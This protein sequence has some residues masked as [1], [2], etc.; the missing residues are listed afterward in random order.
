MRILAIVTAVTC[1]VGADATAQDGGTRLLQNPTMSATQIAFEYAND[2]WVVDRSGG[3]ARRLTSTPV[4]EADVELSPD[5]RWIAFTGAYD[6]NLDVYVMPV[7]GGQPRRLTWHPGDDQVRGWTPDGRRVVFLSGRTNAPL[8][9]RFWTVGLDADF[10][11]VMP[12]PRAYQGSF[13]PDGR[14]FA[15]RMA[16]PTDEEWR[17][18]RG[19]QNRPIW[20]LDLDDYDLEEVRPWDDS[21]DQQPVW[22]GETVYFLSDRDWTMNVWSYDT[23]TRELRQVTEFTDFDVKSLGTD[24]KTLVIE[25]AGWI[26]TVDPETGGRQRLEITVRG[27]FPWMQPRWADVSDSVTNAQLSA[28]GSEVLFE[29]RGDIL[30]IPTDGSA[31]RN[32]TA[33]SGMAERSPAASPDGRWVSWFSDAS[34]E[35]R[36]VIAPLHGQGERREIE[37]PDPKFYYTPAWSPDSRKVAFVGNDLRLWC[38]DIETET[39][40]YVDTEAWLD[41]STTPTLSP[42][43]SPDSRWIAYAK[44]LDNLLHAIFVYS[45][46]TGEIRQVTDG[47]ADALAPAWD[48][49]GKYLSFLAGTDVDFNVGSRDLANRDP[50]VLRAVYL[51]LLQRG[52]PSPFLPGARDGN[53]N[54]STAPGTLTVDAGWAASDGSS[55]GLQV[56]IDFSGLDRRIVALPV[57]ERTYSRLAAGPEGTVFYLETPPGAGAPS[58]RNNDGEDAA[59]SVL[60]RYDLRTR[61]D[62]ELATGV[63]TFTLSADRSRVLYRTGN[64]WIVVSTER[65]AGS[66]NTTA[67]D[68]SDL[69]V[70]IDPRA[71]FRQMFNE[72]WRFQRDYLYAD[73]MH[74]VD[75]VATKARYAPLLE[76]VRHRDDLSYLLDWMGSEV[77]IGHSWVRGGD[78]PS[79]SSLGIGLLGADLEI[80]DGRYRIA[81]VYEGAP[82]T[83][84]RMSPLTQPGADVNEGEYLLAVNGV[85]LRAPSNPYRLFLGTAGNETV[86]R[87]GPNPDGAGSRSVTVVPLRSER[88][89]RREQWTEDNRR[90]VDE[91]S[92]G[93]L[94]YVWVPNNADPGY[95]DFN[96]YYFAQQDREGAVIDER[97]NTGGESGA[98]MIDVLMREP[99]GY[100]NNPIADRRLFT[101]PE[102][103]IWGPKVMIINEHAMSGGDELAY[104]FRYYGIGP[105]VGTRTWG[106]VVAYGNA[107]TLLDGGRMLA[108]RRAFLD[109]DGHWAV[110]NEGVAPDIEVE[111]TPKDVIAGRD[112]QLERAVQEALR[113]LE[114]QRFERK[115]EPP[116]PVRGRR[117]GGGQ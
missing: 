16:R 99:H 22:V 65:A 61:Q 47:L 10:P 54:A 59:P 70:P 106:G 97:F 31:W 73:N 60:H 57:P 50:A 88:G 1:L 89:L 15:Y 62:V 37:M 69:R 101:K 82:W 55:R 107:P 19:G 113:L 86:I 74:G 92:A 45:V 112:P 2:I 29:G 18:Y 13:S 58:H 105:L 7:E 23:R 80:A 77:A 68:M 53:G 102:A 40:R 11:E 108:P 109:I 46:E 94:A 81:R 3:E 36:L 27:D 67:V 63:T 8:S 87:V 100:A 93:R 52:E 104:L 14:R 6:D 76:H 12:M 34:G 41:L 85:D 26:H 21:D 20:I 9:V 42:V 35:Y 30:A 83:P 28:T 98:Y 4:E 72:G 114:T 39:V 33:T 75:Y 110:E 51:A 103:G 84:N 24:G 66:G 5:G 32:L 43:W 91:L 38:A 78:L 111:M 56:D 90:M 117:P 49:S 79:G 115:T 48:A 71:E 96:R 17:N 95:R 64:S 44:R 116:R 25:Q